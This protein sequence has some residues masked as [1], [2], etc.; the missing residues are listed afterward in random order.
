MLYSERRLAPAH[1][2]VQSATYL[3]GQNR[4][5]IGMEL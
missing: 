3:Q 5:A 4:Q 2:A 1:E